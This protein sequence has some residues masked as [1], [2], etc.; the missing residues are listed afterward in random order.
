MALTATAVPNVQVSRPFLFF[1][2]IFFRVFICFYFFILIF[3]FADGDRSAPTC[4]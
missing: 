4:R 1:F 3:V 2:S